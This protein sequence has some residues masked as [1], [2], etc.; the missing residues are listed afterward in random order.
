MNFLQKRIATFRSQR[1]W[2]HCQLRFTGKLLVLRIGQ[3]D[4]LRYRLKFFFLCVISEAGHLHASLTQN[5]NLLWSRLQVAQAAQCLKLEKEIDIIVLAVNKSMDFVFF[6]FVCFVVLCCIV[7]Q[8]SVTWSATTWAWLM[9][10]IYMG[11]EAS[12]LGDYSPHT[13]ITKTYVD[14]TSFQ[15][16]GWCINLDLFIGLD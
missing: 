3:R 7:F 13:L 9:S 6:C 5:D 15:K 12:S 2:C 1:T 11:C 4:I 16:T 8:S 10:Q 14:C